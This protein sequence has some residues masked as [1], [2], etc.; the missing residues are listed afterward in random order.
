MVD[1][2]YRTSGF[3]NHDIAVH[4]TTSLD[5]T[6][7]N[8]S[9]FHVPSESAQDIISRISALYIKTNA[10]EMKG[11]LLS[12]N[13]HNNQIIF[14]ITNNTSKDH[15]RLFHL[16]QKKAVLSESQGSLKRKRSEEENPG[17]R[18]ESL[19]ILSKVSIQLI[20]AIDRI[21]QIL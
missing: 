19:Y 4:I 7:P 20:P 1:I 21:C 12:T 5:L 11:N 9:R 17:E 10:S 6:K 3:T 15:I 13:K 14:K 8:I 2:N 18:E 16:T